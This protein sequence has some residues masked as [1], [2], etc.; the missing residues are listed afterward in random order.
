MIFVPVGAN[1]HVNA[2]DEDWGRIA[3]D[4][5]VSEIGDDGCLVYIPSLGGGA[6]VWCR[7][8]DVKVRA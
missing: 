5:V 3:A 6:D 8:E 2:D 1:V 4:G 7:Y